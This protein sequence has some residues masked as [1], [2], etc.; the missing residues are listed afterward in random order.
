MNP[1]DRFGRAIVGQSLSIERR[2]HDWALHFSDQLSLTVQCL[3]RLRDARGLLLSSE[4]DGHQFGLPGPLNVEEEANRRIDG[5]AVV[6]L[7]HGVVPPDFTVH[8]AN[9][10]I[11]EV[12]AN[13][14]GY[15][16]WLLTIDEA[17]VVGRCD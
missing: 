16:S 13:S 10:L 6:T 4:D 9:G 14:V 12:I 1:W 17:I 8:L 2:E 5:A 7:Q 3:W 11:V 15:E